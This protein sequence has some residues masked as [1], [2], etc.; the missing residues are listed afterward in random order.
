MNQLQRRAVCR[1]DLTATLRPATTSSMTYRRDTVCGARQLAFAVGYELRHDLRHDI[2]ESVYSALRYRVE[3]REL[4]GVAPLFQGFRE[5]EVAGSN[6]VAPTQLTHGAA[7]EFL[8]GAVLLTVEGATVCVAVSR[9]W[10]RARR[11]RASCLCHIRSARHRPQAF[12]ITE[13]TIDARLESLLQREF[14]TIKL[15]SE[16]TLVP[17]VCTCQ[18]RLRPQGRPGLN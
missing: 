11:P 14:T 18:S 2:R 9:A 15:A 7:W 3:I 5:Q 8:G 1:A 10:A 12:P 16:P 17:I 4:V 13:K 6:P